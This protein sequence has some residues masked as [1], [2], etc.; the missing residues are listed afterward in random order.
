M[1]LYIVILATA[2][3][4]YNILRL[5]GVFE[6]SKKNSKIVSIIED[7]RKK[8][9]ARKREI[10]NL[11]FY[12]QYTEMFYGIIMN[13]VVNENHQYFIQRLDIRSEILNR[14]L[15]PEELR[16]KHFLPVI[17]GIICIPLGL[18]FPL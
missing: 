4:V 7:D 14:Q 11:A 5:F 15:T 1:Y 10:N 17:V 18:F 8:N 12:A 3:A 13:A 16:G 9:K 2:F 6:F